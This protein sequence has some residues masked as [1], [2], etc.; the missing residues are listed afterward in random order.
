MPCP[1]QSTPQGQGRLPRDMACHRPK[2]RPAA[3]RLRK[4]CAIL[5][6]TAMGPQLCR[7]FHNVDATPSQ[8]RV[9][10][11]GNNFKWCPSERGLRLRG[12]S[13]PHCSWLTGFRQPD[14]ADVSCRPVMWRSRA[15][16][17]RAAGAPGKVSR[18]Q[19]CNYALMSSGSN[20]VRQ[21]NHERARTS[22]AVQ[23]APVSSALASHS[24]SATSAL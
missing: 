24:F 17:E 11:P 19:Y 23:S 21:A 4:C 20:A 7:N 3:C 13:R 14:G 8:Q 6:V 16:F 5:L 22:R 2:L 1:A 12:A 9:C 15:R 10:A 18:C